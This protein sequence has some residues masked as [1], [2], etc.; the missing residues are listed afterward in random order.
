MLILNQIDSLSKRFCSN[1]V[2][3]R[4]CPVCN[5]YGAH[6]HGFYRR[7]LPGSAVQKVRVPRFLCLKCHKTFSC[8]PF[9]LVRRLGISLS[10]LLRCAASNDPWTVLEEVYMIARSTLWR[11]RRL[12]KK[13]LTALPELLAFFGDSWVEVSHTIS[14]I[15]YPRSKLKPHSTEAGN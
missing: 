11:W 6:K 13:L 7:T 4:H 10:G 15:Q 14:R 9:C 5:G 8:L 12:G 1:F 2:I 3:R